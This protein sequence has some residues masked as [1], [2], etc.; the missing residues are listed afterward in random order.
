MNGMKGFEVFEE[1]KRVLI[2]A[3]HPDDW[4]TMCGG[5]VYQLTRAGV[6]VWGV[7]CTLGDIGSQTG[8]VT[9]AEVA[10]RRA[11]EVEAAAEIL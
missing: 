3:A 1:A 9:R 10:V 6:A 4:E 8:G 2:V 7:N 5:T 11:G